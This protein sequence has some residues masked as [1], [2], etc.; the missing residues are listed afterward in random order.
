VDPVTDAR[1]LVAERFPDA[2][3][4]L[5][6]GGVLGAARTPTSDLD[7]VV[8]TGRPPAPYRESVRWRGWPVELFVNDEESL[9]WY[10]DADLA[11][12]KPSLA[13]M[14]ATSVVLVDR[15]GT[16]E[17]FRTEAAERLAAGPGPLP[18]EDLDYLRYGVADLTD[19]LRGATD[20]GER[21]FI[22][23]SLTA[24]TAE[25]ILATHQH[26]VGKSKWL[27]RELRTADPDFAARLVA[28][29]PDADALIELAVEAQNRAGGRL[30]EG[31]HA[32]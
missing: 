12:R 4:A 24:A 28:A 29:L 30:W 2:R 10:F 21:A 18:A 8:M 27:L 15:D 32:D 7:I 23:W 17:T 3:W 20:E 22:A 31:F 13:R 16:A 14:C 25:L 26:W 19:D 6:G 1:D 11:A 9:R 5:L